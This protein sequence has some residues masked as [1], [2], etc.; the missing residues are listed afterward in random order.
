MKKMLFAF[1]MVSSVFAQAALLTFEAGSQTLNGINLAKT[2]A[3]NDTNGAPTDAKLDL[4]GAGLRTKT[5]L[6]VE[7][8][9]YVAQL[10]SDNK[11]GFSR[12]A[13]A[14]TSLVQNST[15]VALK[16]DMLRTVSA[17]SL[18]TSFKEALAA[19]NVALDAELTNVL[20]L[21]QKSAD[22][23]SG[24]SI[25]ML[26]VKDTKNANKTN[27]Y[28]EDTKGALKSVTASPELMGKILSIW[29]GKPA[30]DGLAALKT[31]LLKAVY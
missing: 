19:N 24:K 8:K 26:M 21:M 23:T 17:A 27:L 31:Q 4:L 6:V 28:Y 13:N 2:A 11:A 22:A 5:V 25:S 1:V 9:V 20:D 14:L 12:D 30:D 29:L 18:V 16:L 3:I 10:F 7:A 15:R